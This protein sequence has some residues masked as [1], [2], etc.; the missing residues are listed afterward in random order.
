[1]HGARLL[2]APPPLVAFPLL[3]APQQVPRK[4]H[5]PA[6]HCMQSVLHGTPFFIACRIANCTF[7]RRSAVRL[8]SRSVSGANVTVK[9]SASA[10]WLW[11]RCNRWHCDTARLHRIAP[12]CA[13]ACRHQVGLGP[14]PRPL[15][16][17]TRVDAGT[18]HHAYHLEH[19]TDLHTSGR[20][21]RSFCQTK[22]LGI[23][24]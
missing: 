6:E 11:R 21:L 7:C 9:V 15:D 20:A 19:L 3:E 14:L 18:A 8:L 23:H 16:P 13:D 24:C 17:C 12:P 1:M 10:G 5:L 4:P 22:L 2:I